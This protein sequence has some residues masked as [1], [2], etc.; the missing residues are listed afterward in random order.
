MVLDAGCLVEFAS[1]AELLTREDSL[2]RKL[3]DESADK[4]AL[5]AMV[6]N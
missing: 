3:V 4:S 6:G 5:H 1:P 2:F